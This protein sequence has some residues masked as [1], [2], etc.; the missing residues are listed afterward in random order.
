[1]EQVSGLETRQ[2]EK[3]FGLLLLEVCY[4]IVVTHDC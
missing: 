1:M 3:R 2:D 4:T